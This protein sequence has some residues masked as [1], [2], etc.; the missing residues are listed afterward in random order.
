MSCIQN[1]IRLNNNYRLCVVYT[2][3]HANH[4]VYMA[5]ELQRPLSG[6]NKNLVQPATSDLN[7]SH[8]E[9]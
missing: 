9:L 1:V 8:S 6:T 2:L 5:M 7:I 4:V 3:Y